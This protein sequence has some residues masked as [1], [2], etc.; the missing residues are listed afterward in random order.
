M[1]K[2]ETKTNEVNANEAK[3]GET[4]LSAANSG[5]LESR[6]MKK[7]TMKSGKYGTFALM[8]LTSFVVMYAAMYLNTYELDHVYFSVT[9]FYM[10]FLM[11]APM[12]LIM[13]WF[14]RGMYRNKKLNLTIVGVSVI[15][16]TLA[17]IFV[18]SQTFI[19]DKAYMRA[20]IPHHSI[21]I[22]TSRRADIKDPEVRKLAD[23][24]IEAQVREI[25]EMKRLLEKPEQ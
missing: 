21:A 3:F 14:M 9:R 2:T 18:R 17:L 12:A 24:I 25:G 5:A 20:M 13:L 22:M 8:M 11:V 7:D 15:A 1:E 10:T 6:E 19:G 4:N 23:G 16:F